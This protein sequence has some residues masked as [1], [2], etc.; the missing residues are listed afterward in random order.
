[1]TPEQIPK[2]YYTHL[3]F[4]FSLINPTTFRLEPMDEIT[5]SKYGELAALNKTQ[6]EL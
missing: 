4:S 6:P 2:G 1:M 3:F 5:G